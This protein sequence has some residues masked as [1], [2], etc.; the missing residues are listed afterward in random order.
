[1]LSLSLPASLFPL[2]FFPPPSPP[3]LFW[4]LFL[5]FD[6]SIESQS[7][8]LRFQEGILTVI[9]TTEYL[10][11]LKL[12]TFK[13][14]Y[15]SILIEYISFVRWSWHLITEIFFLLTVFNSFLRVFTLTLI[16]HDINTLIR[17]ITLFFLFDCSSKCRVIHT[18][19]M[20][21]CK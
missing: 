12:L 11:D 13:A 7:T 21:L 17:K 3:R 18:C 8:F 2:P 16:S 1:M 14:N 10:A 9:L 20:Q 4:F 19:L 5:C 6:I 15:C